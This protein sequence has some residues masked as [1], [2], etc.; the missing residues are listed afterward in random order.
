[1]NEL[2]GI[3]NAALCMLVTICSL[4]DLT[5]AQMRVRPAFPRTTTFDLRNAY[6]APVASSSNAW[7]P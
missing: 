4:Q 2:A 3:R 5:F 7:L 1:M 6:S